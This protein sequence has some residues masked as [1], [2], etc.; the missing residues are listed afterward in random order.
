LVQINEARSQ[1]DTKIKLK[2]LFVYFGDE[3][4]GRVDRHAIRIEKLETRKESC[5][6]I[7]RIGLSVGL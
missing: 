3:I 7:L 5:S 2:D 1:S 6:E 4:G